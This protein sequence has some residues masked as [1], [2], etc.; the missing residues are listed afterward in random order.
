MKSNFFLIFAVLICAATAVFGQT[1]DLRNEPFEYSIQ[2][3][4]VHELLFV[5]FALTENGQQNDMLLDK[6]SL[7]YQE[8]MR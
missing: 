5:V 6:K 8:V 1:N 4:E 2:I 3:Q 7:Y